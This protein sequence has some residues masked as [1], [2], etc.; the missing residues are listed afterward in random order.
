MVDLDSGGI[1]VT[2]DAAANVATV[3]KGTA[4][5]DTIVDVINACE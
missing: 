5:T 1:T 2:V 3:D 4:G